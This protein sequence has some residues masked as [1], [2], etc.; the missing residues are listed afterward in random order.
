[1]STT[2][3]IAGRTGRVILLGA[4][5]GDPDLLTVR[6]ARALADAD[7]LLYD[8]LVDR[9]VLEL[10]PHAQ[11]F[12]VGKRR[13]RAA[14][15][16][17]TINA[18]LIRAASRRRVVVRVKAGDP[19]V[20]GRGAEEALACEA[21]GIRC[22]VI[23]G[24][25]SAIAGPAAFGIPVTHRG[26]APGF[27]V[28]SAAPSIHYER[29]LARLVPGSVTVVL[30]MALAARTAITAFL[31]E[32]GWPADLPAAIVVGATSPGAWS[33]TGRLDAL[34]DVTVPEDR[35]ELPGLVVLGHVVSL[36]E[37]VTRAS[38]ID[39]SAAVSPQHPSEE[40]APWQ[41]RRVP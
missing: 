8:A 29:V 16:Q 13:G 36:S 35:A 26:V 25:T 15:E 22:E 6:A 9:R 12:F 40:E 31:L 28:L 11:R 33:W 41:R 37:A 34:G 38:A 3:A 30:M 18:L 21:A 32:A 10:A 27:L 7:L 2:S 19:F 23:P 39:S 5:P 20:L 17:S 14:M 24:L 4:G 1:M